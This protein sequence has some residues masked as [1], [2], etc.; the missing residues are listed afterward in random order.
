MAWD[1]YR[2]SLTEP[3]VDL[4]SVAVK[5]GDTAI[6]IGANY[7][8]YC[9]H[10]SR[11]AGPSGR[12][13]AFEPVPFTHRTLVTV[14]KLLRFDNNVTIFDKGCSDEPGLISFRV[15]LQASG[16]KLAGQ[17]CISRREDDRPGKESQVRWEKTEEVQSEVVALDQFLNPAADLS[18]IKCDIEGAELL[19]FRGAEGLIQK[20]CPTVLCEINPW[21]LEGFGIAL[22]DLVA[23][24]ADKGYELYAYKQPRTLTKI[25]R[26]ED[27]VEDN[28]VFIHARRL[29]LFSSL[30]VVP[31]RETPVSGPA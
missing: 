17:A 16:A 15:P 28:Y 26:I 24:F 7:G 1:I 22:G 30:T 31:A 13:Y 9:Y 3:E 27:I 6:D 11:A 21:F 20:H 18:L 4:V 29:R 14:S 10:L 8:L 5:P 19:A 23:F 25:G 12:V 2:G